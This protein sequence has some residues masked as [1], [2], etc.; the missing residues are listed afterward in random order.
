MNSAANT[1][2]QIEAR[3]MNAEE[4]AQGAFQ[5]ALNRGWSQEEAAKCYDEAFETWMQD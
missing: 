3:K 4:Q 1:D 2:N 5:R